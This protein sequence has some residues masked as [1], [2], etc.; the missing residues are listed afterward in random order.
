M[1][2]RPNLELSI[3]RLILHGLEGADGHGLREAI[4]AELTRLLAEEGVPPSL[5]E[6][7][8]VARLPGGK[9]DVAPG[10]K[11]AAIAAQVARAVYGGMGG[12]AAART[13][14]PTGG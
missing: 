10:A 14:T 6:G 8:H 7:G 11:P 12:G 2:V 3:D 9:F 5:A 1:G 13:G 4:E